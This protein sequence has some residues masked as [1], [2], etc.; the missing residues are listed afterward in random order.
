MPWP[1]TEKLL[2]FSEEFMV[3]SERIKNQVYSRREPE[4]L[5]M[6]KAKERKKYAFGRKASVVAAKTTGIIG[7]AMSCTK[8]I[9][10]RK[11]LPLS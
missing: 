11:T 3:K 8:N 10:D 2:S 6:G 4:V 1:D 5:C 7:G 9:Y